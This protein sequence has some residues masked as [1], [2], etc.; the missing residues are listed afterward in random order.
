MSVSISQRGWYIIF[1]LPN[2][3]S[4]STTNHFSLSS[5]HQHV[6]DRLTAVLC[7]QQLL[8]TPAGE[9]AWG[10]SKESRRSRSKAQHSIWAL[11]PPFHTRRWMPLANE[12]CELG[13]FYLIELVST[14]LDLQFRNVLLLQ[15]FAWH[16]CTT[17]N[18]DFRESHIWTFDVADFA[19]QILPPSSVSKKSWVL[20]RYIDCIICIIFILMLRLQILR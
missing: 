19:T 15:Q 2:D 1:D 16:L 18:R 10:G 3:S 20:C 7:F 17:G 11:G 6:M 14:T 12:K 9:R 5:S 8:L 4:R 13:R